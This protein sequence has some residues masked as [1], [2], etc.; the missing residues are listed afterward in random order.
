VNRHRAEVLQAIQSINPIVQDIHLHGSVSKE[1]VA[2]FLEENKPAI[3]AALSDS[4]RAAGDATTDAAPA[5]GAQA[6]GAE[7]K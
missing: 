6:A 7:A 5:A 3:T 1:D 4:A 2:K